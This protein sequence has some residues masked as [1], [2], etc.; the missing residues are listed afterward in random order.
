[1]AALLAHVQLVAALLVG[2]GLGDTVDLLHVG[3]Q[4]AALGEGLLTEGTLV[5]ADPCVGKKK[6]VTRCWAIPASEDGAVC[7]YLYVCVHVA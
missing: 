1:M 2:I 7:I 4:R 6:G 5:W 3:L